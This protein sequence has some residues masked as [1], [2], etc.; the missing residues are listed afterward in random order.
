MAFTGRPGD[1]QAPTGSWKVW[2]DKCGHTYQ[3][4]HPGELWRAF[5]E[6]ITKGNEMQTKEEKPRLKRKGSIILE[7]PTWAHFCGCRSH[8]CPSQALNIGLQAM[9]G[10]MSELRSETSHAQIA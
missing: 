2:D 1:G 9:C 8:I 6:G 4:E 10:V 5:Q 3:A 7:A